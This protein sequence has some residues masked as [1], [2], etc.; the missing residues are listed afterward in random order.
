MSRQLVDHS[1]DLQQLVADGYD[2]EI[3]GAQLL[4]KDVPYARSDRSVARGIL[5][6]EL[7]TQGDH[8]IR[9]G[10]HVVWFVGAIPCDA[11]GAELVKIISERRPQP[12]GD[13]LE[14]SCS[15][16]SKP[17][18]GYA[19]YHEKMTAY[20]AMLE[21]NA[22]AIDPTVTARTFPP[23]TMA[24]TES[25]FRYLDSATSRARIAAVTE[26]LR[27]PKV[28]IVGMGGTGS[29]ILDLIAKTPVEEIHLYDEDT[30]YTHNAFRA[31]SAASLESLRA[32][33][34]KVDYF[35]SIYDA[36]HRG[37]IPHAT[38]ITEANVDELR[39]ATFVFL[40]MEG[41]GVKRS[42]VEALESYG[43][44]FIDVGMGIDQVGDSLSGLVRTTTSFEGNRSHI[45]DRVSFAEPPVDD[46]D[47]NIQIADLNM[48]NAALAV[49]KWKKLFGFYVDLEGE[50]SSTYTTDGNHMLNEDQAR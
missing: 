24:E 31:P 29:Y 49:I 2:V 9:P 5:V 10:N 7:S 33:P 37:I 47:Q 1:P 6:S 19:D 8:T 22:C 12:I 41:G 14:A 25:V 36:M 21:H 34:K 20:V 26:K 23:I 32:G 28:A 35:R 4:V 3:R 44:P 45:R 17:P 13:G 11:N 16:S 40:A 48:L 27:L 46:Y 39:D 30:F 15:F 50:C 18:N 43:V 38:Q 42:I